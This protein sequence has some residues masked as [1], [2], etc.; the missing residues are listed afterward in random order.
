VLVAVGVATYLPLAAWRAP[1]VLAELA[2]IRRDRRS[3][4]PVVTQ[5]AEP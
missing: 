4:Q 1:E 3:R 5:I 2:S